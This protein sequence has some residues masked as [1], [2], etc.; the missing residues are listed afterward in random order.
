[1][2]VMHKTLYKKYINFVCSTPC[3]KCWTS[4][5]GLYSEY[6][7][8][9]NNWKQPSQCRVNNASSS[10]SQLQAR[11]TVEEYQLLWKSFMEFSKVLE[12]NDSFIIIQKLY[13]R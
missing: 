5:G 4:T 8:V 9:V 3:I 1:M 10:T 2:L 13:R 6:N 7:L 11:Y 12:V